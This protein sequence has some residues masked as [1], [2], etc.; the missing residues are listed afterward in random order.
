MKEVI[1]G[2]DFDGILTEK[3]I[4]PEIGKMDIDFIN[5]LIE[6]K[7]QGFILILN[8]G[9]DGI[10]LKMAVDV[11]KELGLEFDYVNDNVITELN[12][13][14]LSHKIYADYHYDDHSFNWNKQHAIQHIRE[15][16]NRRKDG[17]L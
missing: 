15:L 14:E 4:F 3:V 8:T 17:T 11:C 10:P 12:G 16:I 13:F 9:R 5:I 1:L 6:A 2:I 7:Q